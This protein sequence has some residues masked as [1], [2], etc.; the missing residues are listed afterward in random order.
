MSSV[1]KV[2]TSRKRA[3]IQPSRTGYLGSKNLNFH[4]QATLDDLTIDLTNLNGYIP[5]INNP[6]PSDFANVQAFV[7]NFSLKSETRE[8]E[9]VRNIDFNISGTIITFINGFEALEDEKFFGA[10][11]LP[12]SNAI[13]TESRTEISQF[14]LPIGTVLLNIGT[15]YVVNANPT[16]QIGTIKVFR[17]GMIQLR[18]EGN[19][20]TN[21]GNY[22]EIDSGN[23]F[24]NSIQ[25]KTA[26]GV[27]IDGIVVDF[28]VH[29]VADVN[30]FSDLERL[31]GSILQLS[32]DMADVT[33]NPVEDYITASA[34]E[35][36]RLTLANTVLAILDVD[37]PILTEWQDY[38]PVTQGLGTVTFDY[39][40]W[41]QVGES[42]EL[43]I[44]GDVGTT[45][46]VEFQVGLPNSLIIGDTYSA[47][48]VGS[49]DRNAI[50]NISSITALA[51]SGDAY[52]N[53]GQR[54][55]S[56]QLTFIPSNGSTVLATGNTF[57]LLASV[58]ISG[59]AATQKI[60]DLI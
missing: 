57:N 29:Q 31:S 2:N 43:Q 56:N 44:Q 7:A 33:G 9:L 25:F 42:I 17:D 23:G 32:N 55:D 5:G 36:D 52:L 47:T 37:V 27:S 53:V 41:R 40:R 3:D 26:N 13:V 59:L 60:S 21:E 45:T 14:E 50:T 10:I 28:G 39:A 20:I 30:I 8:Y 4:H 51:T 35:T 15:T 6:S 1:K 24:G 11:L 22:I 48:K 46:A 19:I 38:T 12:T 54:G 16:Q 49:L 58:K 34:S 18:C